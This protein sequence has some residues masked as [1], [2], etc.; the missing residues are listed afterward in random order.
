MSISGLLTPNNYKLYCESIESQGDLY[1]TVTKTVRVF[2]NTDV[3]I[4]GPI[5]LRYVVRNGIC[6]MWF[7]TTATANLTANANYSLLYI[8]ES[9]GGYV[10][11]PCPN[12]SG[13]K[14][15]F[16]VN[17]VT[18]GDIVRPASMEVDCNLGGANNG[19][20]F[21]SL[22]PTVN[23]SGTSPNFTYA[24]N[25]GSNLFN[26]KIG[27]YGWSISYPVEGVI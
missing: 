20:I 27:L 12:V 1:E 17:L 26:V 3:D 25:P 22:L 4:F 9:A 2:S 10:T 16:P 24:A 23:A 18:Q 6:T 19:R 21:I 5:S 7:P 8:A 14:L 15:F 11:I 13:E